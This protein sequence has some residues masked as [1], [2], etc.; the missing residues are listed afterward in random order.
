M[1]ND[2]STKGALRAMAPAGSTTLLPVS[3][4]GDWKAQA[5]CVGLPS[6]Y[7]GFFISSLGYY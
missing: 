2:G 6:V 3:P 1:I 4:T 7:N 5:M